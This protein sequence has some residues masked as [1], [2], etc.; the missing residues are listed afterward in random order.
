VAGVAERPAVA[1]GTWERYRGDCATVNEKEWTRLVCWQADRMVGDTSSDWDYW[2][3]K[4]G[5]AGHANDGR[6]MKRLWVEAY[7]KSRQHADGIPQPG[8]EQEGPQGSCQTFGLSA[9]S[10]QP[11]AVGISYQ[12]T[13]CDHDRWTPKVY[14]EEGRY[15]VTW[16]AA[17]PRDDKFQAEVG[18]IIPVR[19]RNGEL[20]R[21]GFD[22]HGQEVTKKW[23]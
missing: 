5:A 21:W 12:R 20:P 7:P 2:Q 22:R 19:V 4:M 17:K 8:E 9:S 6:K 23:M 14:G 16:R 13:V 15:S 10:G 18:L 3:L 11:V 1:A